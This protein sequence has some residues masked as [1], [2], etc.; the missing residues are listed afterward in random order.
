ML[1]EIHLRGLGVIDDALLELSDGLNVVTGETG[2]GKTMVVQ[3]LG[4]LLG[5]RADPGLVRAGSGQAVVE[6]VVQV[7]DGEPALARAVEAGADGEDAVRDGLV[8]VRSV[9]SAG[10]SR[11]HIGGRTAPIGVLAEIGEHLV[12]VHGQADQWRLQRPDQHRVVLDEFGGVTLA[13]TR[14][15]YAT[16]FE[17]WTATRAELTTLREESRERA[18]RLELLTA[19]LE[20]VAAI[21][22]QPG[23]D[24]ALAAQSE[25][26]LHVDALREAAAIAHDALVG[27][28]DDSERAPYV[29][30]LVSR[31]RQSLTGEGEHD[32]ELAALADRLR[33]IGI[34]A[35]ELGADLGSYLAG[36]DIE[37][38]RLEAV[39]QRRAALGRLTRKYGA[40][41]TEVLSWA[42]RAAASVDALAGSDDRIA[43]LDVR[44]E[45]LAAQLVDAA[46]A[47][48]AARRTAAV[49]L[50]EL[51]AQELIHLAM[52]SARIEVMVTPAPGEYTVHGVDRVEIML[53]ANKGAAL[54]NLAKAASGGE[55]SRVMLALEVVT[56][57]GA[58]PTFVFDEVDAGVGGAA[59]LDVGARLQRLAEHAQVIVVTHLAQVAAYAD[60][61]LV[62]RKESDGQVTQSDVSVVEGDDRLAELARMLGGVSHSQVAQDH[63]RELLDAAQGSATGATGVSAKPVGRRRH[64]DNVG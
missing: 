22:P 16:L 31:A 58:V 32:V 42:E 14:S 64:A 38:G 30:D 35:G 12:A 26:M 28:D 5:G 9:S 25:R 7:A 53:A 43:H 49:T 34:L 1:Q 57:S 56:G 29:V 48:T 18:Q 15:D 54:R 62:V 37:P 41:V 44:L 21:D 55:L 59:A 36:L 3:G 23:E 47:L 8:L 24:D 39:Q 63:A 11:A 6:G 17:E 27:D 51:V 45:Q 10:R 52:G 40:D 20:E 60:R 50:Q 33:E 61:H 19:G 2:A 4:L 46:D 13:D